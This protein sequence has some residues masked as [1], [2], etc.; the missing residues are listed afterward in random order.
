MIRRPAEQWCRRLAHL[1]L[2]VLNVLPLSVILKKGTKAP[3]SSVFHQVLFAPTYNNIVEEKKCLNLHVASK[4]CTQEHLLSGECLHKNPEAI[5]RQGELTALKKS[6]Q[7]SV[8]CMRAPSVEFFM[9]E[10]HSCLGQMTFCAT[11]F[12][13]YK[14]CQ[15]MMSFQPTKPN[16]YKI[17]C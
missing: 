11:V 14:Y 1:A 7:A 2:S 6:Y 10:N 9:T 3:Q 5:V 4:C 16:V 17:H 15:K 13:F 12:R 8:L